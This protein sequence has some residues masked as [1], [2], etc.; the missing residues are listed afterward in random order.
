MTSAEANP[1]LSRF[2]N[3]RRP[4]F[5]D[6]LK[7]ADT[8]PWASPFGRLGLIAAC[9]GSNNDRQRDR[10]LGREDWRIDHER[11]GHARSAADGRG[12]HDVGEETALTGLTL[13]ESRAAQAP[14][15]RSV[16]FPARPKN[17]H[18]PFN[19]PT[20]CRKGSQCGRSTQQPRRPPST[21]ELNAQ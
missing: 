19:T 9:S 21:T 1:P 6:S 18:G 20:I 16:I 15:K 5:R 17:W 13:Y 11:I 2:V 4:R 12:P 8:T 3:C 14:R 7:L 10:A